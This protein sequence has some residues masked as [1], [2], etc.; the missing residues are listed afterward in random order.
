MF[1]IGNIIAAFATFSRIPMPH[2]EYHERNTNYSLCF[3]PLVGAVVGA[4]ML[5]VHAL[6]GLLAVGAVLRA[7]LLLAVP[8]LVTGGIHLDGYCDTVDAL[9]SFAPREKKLQILKDPNAGAF[10]VIYC[11]LWYLLYFGALTELD[12]AFFV[13]L[14]G[15]VLSRAMSALAVVN[16]R[17]AR[18]DGMGAHEKKSASRTAVNI[19]MPVFIVLSVALM[20]WL[21]PICGAAGAAAAGLAFLYYRIKSYRIFGGFTGDIAGWF[22]Q[23]SE[24]AVC[25]TVTVA[26]RILLL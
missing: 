9:S 17:S 18:E 21:N 20:V 24:L 15:F 4:L 12:T 23:I 7:A 14:P 2:I 25:L 6:C 13:I 19:M 22:L 5:L 10:A 8:V 11:G 3:F 16:F 1:V 26:E